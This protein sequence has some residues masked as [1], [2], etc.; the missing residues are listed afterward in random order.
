MYGQYP[1]EIEYAGFT[2]IA[3]NTSGDGFSEGVAYNRRRTFTTFPA[4][5]R[6]ILCH[7]ATVACA[8][9]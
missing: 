9:P 4:L 2:V 8:S 5:P 3:D 1:E 7:S 6:V